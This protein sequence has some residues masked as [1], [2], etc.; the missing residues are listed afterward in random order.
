MSSVAVKEMPFARSTLLEPLVWL[1]IAFT[2][3]ALEFVT[4]ASNARWQVGPSNSWMLRPVLDSLVDVAM[5]FVAFRLTARFPLGRPQTVV[6]VVPHALVAFAYAGAHVAIVTIAPDHAGE[7]VGLGGAMIDLLAYALCAGVAHGL[8]YLRRYRAS[9]SAALRLQAEL[10]DAARR[11]A[12]A[13]LRALKAELNPHLLGGALQEVATLVHADP[14]A[15]ERA[16]A[17]LGDMLRGAISRTSTSEITLAE[18]VN[19]LSP[20]LAIQRARFGERLTVTCDI[21]ATTLDACVPHLVLQPLVDV[22]LRGVPAARAPQLRITG[23]RRVQSGDRLSV[24]VSCPEASLT[25]GEYHDA[26]ALV[27]SRLHGVYGEHVSIEIESAEAGGVTARLG[28]PWQD[29]DGDAPAR[30]TSGAPRAPASPARWLVP[31]FLSAF[32]VVAWA[33]ATVNA[34]RTPLLSGARVG[35]LGALIGAVGGPALATAMLYFAIRLTRREDTQIRA[36]VIAGLCLG[37]VNSLYRWAFAVIAGAP[38]TVPRLAQLVAIVVG[39][40]VFYGVLVAVVAGLRYAARYRRSEGTSLRL[41]AA[42]TEVERRRAEAELHALKMELNPHFLGNALGAVS[43]L[44]RRD[45]AAAERVLARLGETLRVAIARVATQ[46][47]TLREEIDGLSPFIEVER[48]RF[49]DRLDVA[50]EV[51]ESALAAHVPHMILQPLVE[52]AV[53][54]GLSQRGG[55]IVVAGRRTG[56]RLELSVRDDGDGAAAHHAG[57]AHERRGGVGLANARA[58]LAQLYGAEATLDLVSTPGAGTTA[59]LSLPWR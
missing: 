31:A 6:N 35:V 14:G 8:M 17:Q 26:V 2:S 34:Y 3:L 33:M 13:E 30:V 58:R 59:R 37:L 47:V 12:E 38:Y 4:H 10:S 18:E 43:S 56:E 9:R 23:R 22:V 20:F 24:E 16:L 48:A 54:H 41:S 32:F 15:A 25:A 27:R 51:D 21:D 45:P 52:N 7:R 57:F 42:L 29:S 1:G 46:E 40:T 5:L 53:K 36:H 44:V 39:T 49:G 28:M 50:W 19:A 11:R 55:R